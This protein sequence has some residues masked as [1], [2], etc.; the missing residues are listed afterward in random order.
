M[1]VIYVISILIIY[2]EMLY[3]AI[4]LKSASVLDILYTVLFSAQIILIINLIC[5]LFK[6]KISKIIL[7][8]ISSV[9]TVWFGT[10]AV[11][12]NLFSVPVLKDG[13][14]KGKKLHLMI[15]DREKQTYQR[16]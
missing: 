16:K 8:I 15:R 10:Q 5:N 6:E 12:L 2:L 4:I 7:L 13:Y 3:K 14:F 11:F 9:I 1:K